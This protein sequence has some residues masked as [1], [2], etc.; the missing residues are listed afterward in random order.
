MNRLTN[1]IS[2]FFTWVLRQLGLFIYFLFYT[3]FLLAQVEEITLD[4]GEL[5]NVD[6]GL[7]SRT[8]NCLYEDT[9]GFIWVGTS[10]G[11]NMY[12]GHRFWSVSNAAVS[13]ILEDKNKYIW[14]A[15]K[16]YFDEHLASEIEILN[17][18]KKEKR[19]IKDID[20]NCLLLNQKIRNF[21]QDKAH[22]LWFSTGNGEIHKY[23]GSSFYLI[24]K[25]ETGLPIND[26]QPIS[27]HELIFIEDDYLVSWTTTDGI[28]EK[29]KNAIGAKKIWLGKNDRV[30]F[31][32]FIQTKNLDEAGSP[33]SEFRT[34]E[35][36]CKDKGGVLKRFHLEDEAD[37]INTR[38]DVF[39]E[40]SDGN[41]WYIWEDHFHCY[42][43]N[44]KLLKKFTIPK[45][46]QE[47]M[48]FS[49]TARGN[50]GNKNIYGKDGT[51]WIA[52]LS[53]VAKF[54]DKSSEFQ[55][56]LHQPSGRSLS[57][58]GIIHI[59]EDNL[60][61]CTYNSGIV[62]LNLKNNTTESILYDGALVQALAVTKDRN[63]DIWLGAHE[64][65]IY[66]YSVTDQH[67]KGYTLEKIE[68]N[69]RTQLQV[70]YYDPI[71]GRLWIGAAREGLFYFDYETES[72]V[73]F[74]K[75]NEFEHLKE[76]RIFCFFQNDE[77]LWIGTDNGIYIVDQ[78]KG[79]IDWHHHFSLTEI[80]GIFHAD[81]GD[82]W[83][84]G[85]G[86]LERWDP[87]TNEKKLFSKK[88]GLSDDYI[89][90]IY[91]DNFGFLW[92]PCNKGLMRFNMSNFEVNTF[93]P[94]AGTAHEEFNLFSHYKDKKG[95]FY[96]GGLNGVTV[97]DPADFLETKA[98]HPQMKLTVLNF[99][100][101]NSGESVNGL[102][103]YVERH[104]VDW[105]P[106][107]KSM[108]VNFILQDYSLNNKQTYAYQ[109]EGLDDNWI[110]LHEN[111][112]RFN[113]LPYGNYTIK[114]KGLGGK[115]LWSS[116]LSIP[117]KVIRPF[118]KSWW[119]SVLIGLAFLWFLFSMF[120]WRVRKLE[121]EVAKRTQQIETDRQLIQTQYE[122]LETLNKTKDRLYS[123]IAHDLRDP[124]T[125]FKGIA[126]KINYLIQ[127]NEPKR[128][129]ELAEY[130]EESADNLSNLLENLLAWAE[131]E[132]GELLFR[133]SK[134]RFE[135]MV[136]EVFNLLSL[137]AS[138]KG[139]TLRYTGCSDSE[140][141]GDFYMLTAILRNLVHNAI[142]F[143]KP[144]SEVIV[145]C[146]K[147]K[148]GLVFTV[149]DFGIGIQED[150]MDQL[151]E[152][153]T[154][155]S[156]VDTLGEKGT[157]L[158]LV[159]CHDLVKKHKGEISV[160]SKKGN[161]TVFRVFIPFGGR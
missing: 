25:N 30:W 106:S 89:Y 145:S 69:S 53:G 66:K 142:K 110:Y 41:I 113:Q 160:D 51:L 123:I 126:E 57:T 159:L 111:Y 139:V 67:P 81:D 82:I 147:E 117:V 79:I 40:M 49:F 72:I 150:D 91:K 46:E 70:P 56:L 127:R 156:S 4:N 90:T 32:K 121:E 125:A 128:V 154:I 80:K 77:K 104:K 20:P 68:T 7:N 5:L 9:D 3:C 29:E 88:D 157:G 50:Y 75:W 115:G 124:V 118:Y 63:G 87:S 64:S 153:K 138:T 101:A 34:T 47:K 94:A 38:N 36:Y 102:P 13:F 122:E 141:F 16:S 96:F 109:I 149:S 10:M 35:L 45:E 146:Q 152:I 60:L 28:I 144:D 151:F 74:Q 137:F 86:G 85:N 2:Q 6:E 100:K 65:L 37:K 39:G 44:G 1:K 92:L 14:L 73:P 78:K 21:K 83:L 107:M 76:A 58:R 42:D 161:A 93:L 11:A 84:A 52:L 140:V 135:S 23:D 24:Y 33:I 19:T 112:L 12:D 31:R 95:R 54:S 59:D 18:I 61:I 55:K 120:R 15:P 131:Q 103:G 114:I 143:S 133:P 43:P 98:E 134:H 97:F 62:K 116:P 129:F 8:I 130:I 22:N 132:R 155:P 27:D 17:P 26:L 148:N 71:N 99:L 119:F 158:G 105:E 108:Q 136:T 48:E